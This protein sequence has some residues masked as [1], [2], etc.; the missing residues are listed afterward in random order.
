[1]TEAWYASEHG[2]CGEASAVS[3]VRRIDRFRPAAVPGAKRFAVR[4]N[5]DANFETDLAVLWLAA[6]GFNFQY[7]GGHS[8][9]LSSHLPPSLPLIP[10]S[11]CFPSSYYYTL[12]ASHSHSL[13]QTY[14]HFCAGA[15]FAR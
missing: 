15:L 7:P 14:T 4:S 11:L 13:Q 1:V 9:D 5:G 6:V 8:R 10:C 2:G 12:A 3:T